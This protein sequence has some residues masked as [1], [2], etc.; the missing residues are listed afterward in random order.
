MPNGL[1]L[2]SIGNQ[3]PRKSVKSPGSAAST[4]PAHEK[5]ESGSHATKAKKITVKHFKETSIAPNP[6]NSPTMPAHDCPRKHTP[7]PHSAQTPRNPNPLYTL[8]S[9]KSHPPLRPA[10][11]AAEL[12]QTYALYASKL[13]P[14]HFSAM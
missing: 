11:R 13:A 7:I 2:T 9:R 12:R 14:L 10:P 5:A 8:A 6:G 1:R 3:I 4:Q